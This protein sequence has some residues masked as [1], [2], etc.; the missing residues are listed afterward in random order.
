M[1]LILPRDVK[2]QTVKSDMV[3]KQNAI[4]VES[5]ESTRVL[6]HFKVEELMK[7]WCTDE[8]LTY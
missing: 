5:N 6:T 3:L 7:Y 8:I 1:E 4:K 2:A